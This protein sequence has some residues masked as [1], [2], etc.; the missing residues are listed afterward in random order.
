M[1]RRAEQARPELYTNLMR[2]GLLTKVLCLLPWRGVLAATTL[3]LAMPPICAACKII[4]DVSI[5][6]DSLLL[7]PPALGSA[8]SARLQ[9]ATYALR[10]WQGPVV[11]LSN[12]REERGSFGPPKAHRT[13]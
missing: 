7:H 4:V 9:P 13:P 3:Q 8:D 11:R 6:L 2:Q 5:F 10:N 12:G 1:S